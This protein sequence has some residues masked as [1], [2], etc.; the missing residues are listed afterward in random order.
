MKGCPLR[1]VWC[2]NPESQKTKPEVMFFEEKCIGCGACLEACPH[3]EV[4]KENWP[5]ITEVC[6]GCGQ[7]VE[8]C[9]AEARHLVGRW[10][11]LDQVL[12]VIRRD[13]V[14]YEQS[15]GGVTVGGGEPT[16]QD[17]FVAALLGACQAEGI[18]TAIETCGFAP[19]ATMEGVLNHVD[20]LLF[21]LKH[22]DSRQH[23]AWTGV[24]NTRILDNARRAA[25]VKEMVVRLPLIPGFNDEPDNLHALGRFVRDEL[26]RVRRI[27]ILPYHSTG[28]SKSQRLSREYALHDCQP[29]SRAQVEQIRDILKRYRVGVRIG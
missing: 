25:A 5:L 26:P 19:W 12:A 1:C 11:T 13:E 27:D 6:L 9:Y 8:A 4:L 10:M 22:M 28:E 24:E 2:S 18:H 17:R 16:Y 21:D 29:L 15:H 14:F 3:G 7:C 20:Q 23:K